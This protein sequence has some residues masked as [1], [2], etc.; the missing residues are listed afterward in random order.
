MWVFFCSSY[1]VISYCIYCASFI[2]KNKQINILSIVGNRIESHHFP[3]VPPAP[4]SC[5][6]DN[7]DTTSLTAYWSDPPIQC[8]VTNHNMSWTSHVLWN[9]EE[10]TGVAQTSGDHHTVRN[11]KPYTN[12]TVSVS[13]ATEAGYGPSTTCWNVT[14]QDSELTLYS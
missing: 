1:D 7:I 11:L 4:P 2:N 12:V 3:T 5:W 10:D 6:F 8:P 9:D 14:L 13:A